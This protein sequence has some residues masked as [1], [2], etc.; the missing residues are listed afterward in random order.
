LV[1]QTS[2][3]KSAKLKRLAGVAMAGL[4]SGAC[5][6]ATAQAAT[7]DTA[8]LQQAWRTS[9]AHTPAPG[10]GCY[11]AAYPLTVWRQVACVT[12]PA[13][14]YIPASGAGGAQTTGDGNDYAAVTATLTQMAVGSFPKVKG[15]KSE[16]GAGGRSNY[17]SLQL[18]S[19]FM[20]NSGACSSAFDTSKCLAW[21][22]FVY[23]SSS[24]ASFMQYWLIHY[25]GGTVHCPSGWNSFSD[26]CY[27]NSA[28]VGVPQQAITEL[29]NISISGAAV[30]GGIDTFV[31]TTAT[32]AY[33][34]TG[35]DSVVFLADGW[36]GSEFNVVGDGGGSAANFNAGTKLT[37]QIDLT[38][39][40][41]AKPVCQADAGTTGE[42]NNLNLG[43]CKAKPGKG[44]KLPFVQ[45]VESLPKT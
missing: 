4:L 27:K 9:I 5:F 19:N 3:P 29:P 44:A 10:K 1:V 21:E 2:N 45:F 32:Q 12:A 16:T 20:S 28:A 34:T 23:S 40:T 36:T 8:R 43:K 11:T 25:T 30:H 37:V 26:D 13:R 6:A 24:R 39:G 33:T 38:D 7:Q 42:T 14:P 18:N 17:Y 31:T 41:T 15:L 22:Q 35:Q